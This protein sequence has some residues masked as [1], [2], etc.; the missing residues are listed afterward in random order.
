AFL[1]NNSFSRPEK[2]DANLRFLKNNKIFKQDFSLKDSSSAQIEFRKN[3][4]DFSRCSFNFG[5]LNNIMSDLTENLRLIL[6]K[7]NSSLE[8][9]YECGETLEVD[10][11]TN[12]LSQTQDL[13]KTFIPIQSTNKTKQSNNN[14]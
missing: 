5:N 14:Q 9:K 12:M 7:R 3:N 4:K 1:S 11:S 2:D 6:R 10:L 8:T 13:F